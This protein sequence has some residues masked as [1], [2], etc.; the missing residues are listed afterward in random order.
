M[1]TPYEILSN[2][3]VESFSQRYELSVQGIIQSKIIGE[4]PWE[5]YHRCS[6]LPNYHEDYSSNLNHPSAFDFL[7]NTVNTV[8][9]EDGSYLVSTSLKNET[10]PFPGRVFQRSRR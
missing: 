6:H 3:Q 8:D 7:S 5:D 9:S 1:F 4:A 2:L 10:T